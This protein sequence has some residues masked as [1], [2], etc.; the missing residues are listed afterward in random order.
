MMMDL[1]KAFDAINHEK[2]RHKLYH[3]NVR[4]TIHELLASYLSERK[5]FVYA[6]N[7]QSELQQVTFGVPQGSILGPLLFLIYI[8]DLRNVLN[9]TP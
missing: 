5:Q 6:N 2:L 1:K 3:C 8:N 7:L 9:S 4:G